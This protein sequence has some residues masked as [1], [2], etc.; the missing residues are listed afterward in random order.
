MIDLRTPCPA[1]SLTGR[2]RGPLRSR[3][4]AVGAA[5]L[6]TAL[7]AACTPG[8]AVDP[9]AGTTGTPVGTAGPATTS[10]AAP[11]SP[12]ATT[13]PPAGSES[14][15]RPDVW[16]G[17]E[18]TDLVEHAERYPDGEV[19]PMARI[20]RML[21]TVC[22]RTVP[23]VPAGTP[24]AGADYDYPESG[25]WRAVAA[26]SSDARASAALRTLRSAV[27]ACTGRDGS[28]GRD[29]PVR[30]R[31][32]AVEAGDEAVAVS[33]LSIRPVGGVQAPR[34]H[35]VDEVLAVRVGSVVW[36]GRTLDVSIAK[37]HFR[38]DLQDGLRRGFTAVEA[39]LR[40]RG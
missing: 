7:L 29:V 2:I 9:G 21:P 25:T 17:F 38:P 36:I 26:F 3:R 5:V 4:Q 12:A 19:K 33:A 22:G 24:Q 11:T 23:A 1:R 15:V 37:R 30:W 13:S 27:A 10:P 35:A 31:S 32:R 34:Y 16:D 39:E 40:E 18:F 8:R 6:V 28:G 20:G 14:T